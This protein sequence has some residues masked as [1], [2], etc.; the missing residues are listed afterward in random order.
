MADYDLSLILS[1]I[2]GR[3]ISK[4]L[5]GSEKLNLN[6]SFAMHLRCVAAESSWDVLIEPVLIN[7]FWR[8]YLLVKY[9]LVFRTR[10]TKNTW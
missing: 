1:F 7:R 9:I 4:F 6:S 3:I 10:D 2:G 5:Y 8:S